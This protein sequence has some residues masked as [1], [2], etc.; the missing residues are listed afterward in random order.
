MFA[1]AFVVV[2]YF[3]KKYFN[4]IPNTKLLRIFSQSHSLQHQKMQNHIKLGDNAW[5]HFFEASPL[6]SKVRIF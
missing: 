6:N 3:H 5:K 2:V 1:F 4:Q